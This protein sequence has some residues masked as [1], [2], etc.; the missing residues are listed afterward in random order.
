MILINGE[1]SDHISINDR[2]L[3]YGDGL[4][5]TIEVNC[6]NPV[7]L[8]RHLQ[9]LSKGCLSL[10]IPA[11][12]LPALTDEVHRVCQESQRAVL[13]IIITRGIGG[14]GY[15]PPDTISPTRIVRLYPFPEY[16]SHY[17]DHGV[18]VRFCNTRLGLNRAL[19]GIKHLNR[20][21]QV[22]ARAE[23]DHDGIQ[24]GIMLDLNGH[25]I[26][27]TMTNLFYI[28]NDVLYTS[29]LQFSGV[30]GIIRDIVMQ[31]ATNR[32]IP[33]TEHFYGKPELLNADEAFV[34]N[35][36]IG[37]WPIKQIE[38]NHF[39]VGQRTKELQ[40]ALAQFKAGELKCAAS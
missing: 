19:A 4:F 40:V 8:G 39:A 22:L 32:Q 21:E 31:L 38:G 36:I 12:D 11:P 15:R 5:E 25:V 34:C 29:S 28:K 7:F 10:S 35:S 24:E 20:L 13:K 14:R 23:W 30:A 6:G 9:R 3:H 18:N 2:G 1:K 27:G 37:I 33:L 26:E 16:P 17:V